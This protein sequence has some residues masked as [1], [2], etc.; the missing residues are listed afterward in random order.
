[1][2]K[3]RSPV[4]HYVKISGEA[5]WDLLRQAA[6]PHERLQWSAFPWWEKAPLLCTIRW[7]FA[8]LAA[9]SVLWGL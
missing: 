8:L 3:R 5:L 9:S 6:R 7:V 2:R 1:M 4:S